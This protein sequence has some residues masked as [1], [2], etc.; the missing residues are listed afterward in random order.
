M[1]PTD[2]LSK[3]LSFGCIYYMGLLNEMM[4]LNQGDITDCSIQ[5]FGGDTHDQ[6]LALFLN[7]A[8]MNR[9]GIS[10][11]LK[12]LCLHTLVYDDTAQEITGPHA[13]KI[14]GPKVF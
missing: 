2:A 3:C 14:S 7:N 11:S 6:V 13:R 8:G 5:Y 9:N 1:F 12:V 10:F 4:I